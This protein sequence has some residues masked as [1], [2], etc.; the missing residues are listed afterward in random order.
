MIGLFRVAVIV[1]IAF[2]VYRLVRRWLT[3]FEQ[4]RAQNAARRSTKIGN[5]VRC[6]YCQ[7]HLPEEQAFRKNDTWYCSKTHYQQEQQQ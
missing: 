5:M 4:N 6:H 3:A 1:L 2:L 7:L